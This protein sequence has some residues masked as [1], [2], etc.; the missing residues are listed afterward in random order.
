MVS[1]DIN[2][3]EHAMVRLVQERVARQKDYSRT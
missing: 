3:D 1:L 2:N